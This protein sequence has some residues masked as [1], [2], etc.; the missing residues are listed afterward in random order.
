MAYLKKQDLDQA[1]AEFLKDI[2]IEPDVSYDY[3]QL[4]EVY[5]LQQQ[6]QAAEKAFRK[7]LRLDPQLA[8]SHF[9]LARVYQREKNMGKR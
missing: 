1:K 7:A 8:S 2:A 9:Q 4:G 5:Y 3:D 6:D